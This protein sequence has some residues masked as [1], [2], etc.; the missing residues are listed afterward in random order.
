MAAYYPDQIARV[1]QAIAECERELEVETDPERRKDL[2]DRLAS[3]R[4]ALCL[5]K[6]ELLASPRRCKELKNEP[7]GGPYKPAAAR[8]ELARVRETLAARRKDLATCDKA[9]DEGRSVIAL[10]EE[11]SILE[12]RIKDLEQ[13]LQPRRKKA[14][15][16]RR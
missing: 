5:Y 2:T 3:H 16:R 13:E 10:Q 11:V 14:A 15:V 7:R 4:N 1:N 9:E 6:C 12:R 8:K